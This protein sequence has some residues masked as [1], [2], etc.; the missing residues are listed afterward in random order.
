MSL[1]LELVSH[2]KDNISLGTARAPTDAIV[3]VSIIVTEAICYVISV[4]LYEVDR[5]TLR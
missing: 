3:S 1:W 4:I 5:L 2:K